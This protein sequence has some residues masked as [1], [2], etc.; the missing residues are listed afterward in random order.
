VGHRL[1]RLRSPI[2]AFSCSLR[3]RTIG[4]GLPT[5]STGSLVSRE[6]EPM[7]TKRRLPKERA[8]RITERA[9]A[10]FKAANWLTLHRALG[11]RPWMPSPLDVKTASPP[12]GRTAWEACWPLAVELRAELER[13]CARR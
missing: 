6:G 4:N 1:K 13:A 11:L 2:R 8:H 9:V 3:L 7:P 5:G 12:L 10:A